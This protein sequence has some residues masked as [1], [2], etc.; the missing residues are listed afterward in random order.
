MDNNQ[1]AILTIRPI[2][3]SDN[4]IIASLIRSVLSEHHANK[5]G[6]AFFDK[7]LDCLY[8]TFK[9]LGSACYFI[10]EKNKTVIGGGGVYPTPG[11]PEGYCELVKLYLHQESRGQGA[12][13]KLI[14]A[15]FAA[16]K[17]AGYTHVYLETM[18]ELNKAVLLYERIGFQHLSSP[19]GRSG[20]FNCN[21]WMSCAIP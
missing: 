15:C 8:E 9:E 19:L 21:I 1:N 12:G 5:P 10:A 20:H 16:A 13:G 18:P 17:K 3:Q 7:S 6:T 11:L 4:Q 2:Q 14:T